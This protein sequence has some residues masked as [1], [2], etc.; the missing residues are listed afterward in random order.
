M[1][2]PERG[3]EVNDALKRLGATFAR[4]DVCD[5]EFLIDS[6]SLIL[7]Y[8]WN[9]E[10]PDEVSEPFYTCSIDC[11]DKQVSQIECM[12]LLASWEIKSHDAHG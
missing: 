1:A 3:G 12:G 9:S 5:K 11:R 4:C 6:S 8:P 10:K 2:Q 7:V